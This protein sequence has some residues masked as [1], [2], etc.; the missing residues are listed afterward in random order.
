MAV[1]GYK[2]LDMAGYAYK[3][4][5]MVKNIWRRREKAGNGRKGTRV[6]VASENFKTV[7]FLFLQLRDE[8]IEMT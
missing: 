2:F 3:L 5:T 6:D 1:N 8:L 7:Y 4:L